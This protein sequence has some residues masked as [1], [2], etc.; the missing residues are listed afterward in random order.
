MHT[1]F[2]VVVLS[3]QANAGHNI[4]FQSCIYSQFMEH[5]PVPFNAIE[6]IGHVSWLM[7]GPAG[8]VLQ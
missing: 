2:L 6:T 7:Y 4:S 1:Y 5:L 8:Y 3:P